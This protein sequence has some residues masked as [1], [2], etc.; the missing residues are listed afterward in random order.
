MSELI[1]SLET[2]SYYFSLMPRDF[3]NMSYKE[4]NR[5]CQANLIK[6][7]DDFKRN[8]ILQEAVTDKMIQ[9]DS[10]SKKPKVVPLRKMFQEL[11]KK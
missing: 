8:I 5:F 10:M 2:L 9:A 7:Q 11:F 1:Y 3:W 6:L 4:I